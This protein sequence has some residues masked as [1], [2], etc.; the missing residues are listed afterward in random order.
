[1]QLQLE[2]S[3]DAAGVRDPEL[4]DLVAHRHPAEVGVHPELRVDREPDQRGGADPGVEATDRLH[5]RWISGIR[6]SDR[7]GM[8]LLGHGVFLRVADEGRPGTAFDVLE[9]VGS[10][11]GLVGVA[12]LDLVEAT[13]GTLWVASEMGVTRIPRNVVHSELPVPDTRLASARLDGRLVDPSAE[14]EAA[15]GSVVDLRFT[16]LSYRDPGMVQYR[17]RAGPDKPWSA[18]RER[19][20]LLLVDPA[21]GRHT[22]EVSATLDGER[23]SPAPARFVFTARPPWYQDWRFLLGLLGALALTLGAA[24]QLRLQQLL[25]VERLRTQVAMDLPDEVGSGLGS[26]GLLAGTAALVP[27]EAREEILGRIVD[28][29]AELGRSLSAIV[30]SLR[31]DSSDLNSLAARLAE[32]GSAMFPGG[33]P[34]LIVDVAPDLPARPMEVAVIRTV[35]LV[36]LEAM[37]NATRH[38][39]G[40]QVRLSGARSRGPLEPRGGRQRSGHRGALG[41]GR[42]RLRARRHAATGRRGGGHADVV[43]AGGGR[44]A[45]RVDL[46]TSRTGLTCAP[47]QRSGPCSTPLSGTLRK[48]NR[49]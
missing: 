11:E 48:R 39:G 32:R 12:P 46:R 49:P 26:I 31:T 14:I 44:D 27:D 4:V 9:S 20:E 15:P 17:F 24:W 42:R 1:M 38:S 22:V 33:D 10:W 35:L 18:P 25:R 5:S 40:T 16:A 23:W 19:P 29:S 36:D 7:G 43:G 41:L 28:T 45:R 8:W 30:W 3:E 13:D 2:A 21:P 37:H 47:R 34:E 6:R